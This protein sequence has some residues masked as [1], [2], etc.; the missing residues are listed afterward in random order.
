MLSEPLEARTDVSY[1]VIQAS[2]CPRGRPHGDLVC[3]LP[4]VRLDT[5]HALTPARQNE[6]VGH[7]RRAVGTEV[8]G[9]TGDKAQPCPGGGHKRSR[10]GMGRPGRRGRVSTS[11]GLVCRVTGA[12]RQSHTG[13]QGGP[14]D[15]RTLH[16][17]VV[18][19]VRARC[20]CRRPR[21]SAVASSQRAVASSPSMP[22]AAA[23]DAASSYT[24]TMDTA[25]SPGTGSGSSAA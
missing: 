2:K 15:R 4:L 19:A 12:S 3:G 20:T 21:S 24:R 11:G 16:E 6:L 23:V 13:S 7:S 8:H 1:P 5:N 9:G 14:S 17:P 22:S 10:R 25:S 18:P